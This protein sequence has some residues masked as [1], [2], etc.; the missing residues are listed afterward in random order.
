MKAAENFSFHWMLTL[1]YEEGTVT[2]PVSQMS[3]GE[4]EDPSSVATLKSRTLS[5]HIMLALAL[6]VTALP[7]YQ[8]HSPALPNLKSFLLP[9]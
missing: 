9:Y 3:P 5:H 6:Q 7:M 8:D 1:A 4:G 2:T